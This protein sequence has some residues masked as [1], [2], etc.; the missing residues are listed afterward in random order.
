MRKFIFLISILLLPVI[1][2][3]LSYGQT[4]WYTQNSGTTSNLN[5]IF[6]IDG[7][8]GWAVGA[9]GIVVKTINRGFSWY[10]QNS[11]TII[12][13]RKIQFINSQTGWAVGGQF[14][15]QPNPFCMFSSVIIKTT[16]GGLTW[17][18]II[19]TDFGRQY[20]D[21][22]ILDSSNAYI[23][24]ES[25]DN[26]QCIMGLGNVTKTTDG[27]GW[28]SLSIPTYT[29]YINKSLSF[30]NNSTGYVTAIHS[31]DVIYNLKKIL[32]TTD[33]GINWIIKTTD[34]SSGFSAQNNFIRFFNEN[35]GYYIN[36]NF[37]KTING[38][39][40]WI[41]FDSLSVY[42]MNKF[43]FMDLSTGYLVGQNKL[44]KTSNGGTNWIT[45]SGTTFTGLNS[46]C[47]V[48]TNHVWACGTGGKIVY[49]GNAFLADTASIKY[50]PLKIGNSWTYRDETNM[51]EWGYLK[52]T[53][54]SDTL[55]NGTT[56]YKLD[57][58]FPYF[59][60]TFITS[61]SLT[62]N[63]YFFLDG[64]DCTS[65]PN[66]RLMDSLNSKP[67]DISY[68][69]SFDNV[70]S[71]CNDTNDITIFGSDQKSKFFARSPSLSG[72][73]Q[74]RYVQNFGLTYVFVSENTH[75]NT[76][77]L[78]GC[79]INN[80]IYGDTTTVSPY[81]TFLPLKVGNRWTYRNYCTFPPL[82]D[83]VTTT[84]TSETTIGGIKYFT[85]SNGFPTVSGNT[86]TLDTLTGNVFV[87]QSGSS[88]ARY[89]NR[90]LVDSLAAHQGDTVRQCPSFSTIGQCWDTT[91][92]QFGQTV[93]TKR[94]FYEGIGY[95]SRT[96]SEKFG[97]VFGSTSEVDYITHSLLSCV[98]DGVNYGGSFKTISGTI[99]FAD[100]NLSASNGYVKAIKLNTANGKIITLDSTQIG[101]NGSY[102][103]THL[104]IDSCDI[105]AYPNSENQADFVPTFYPSTIHWQ[106]ATKVYTGNN[107]SNI[108][109]SVYRKVSSLG[110]FSI[111]GW[112]RPQTA[113]VTGIKDAVVYVMQGNI[114]RDYYCTYDD[115][116]QY[117]L[118][119]LLPGSYQVIA[120]RLGYLSSQQDITITNTNLNNINFSLIPTFVGI[121][122]SSNIVPDKFNLY[123]NYPNPFNPV[124][125]IKFD[126]PKSSFVKLKIYNVLGKEV[127]VILNENKSAGSYTIDFDASTIST[128]IYFYRLETES[129]TETKRMVILK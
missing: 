49:G 14:N 18:A 35:T 13:L 38:G 124:T 33:G 75:L 73:H 45:N 7:N 79:V 83:T 69:C 122:S 46:I 101:V 44:V 117:N 12:E 55:I 5:D 3:S 111:D 43:S 54:I 90:F 100:N 95:A 96:Y 21:L 19:A 67:G 59:I 108:N 68:P 98:I 102:S 22:S 63:I 34:S 103:L 41:K 4:G 9:N 27:S 58:E 126:I 15:P 36:G 56:F 81:K 70:Y 118:N 74:R 10:N 20:N 82:D 107:P 104:P 53:I 6:F 64:A 66:L 48:D 16:N 105:V 30:I 91:I 42:G 51:G 31:S 119:Q 112:I 123:Q 77:R 29:G 23:A 89:P 47:A 114:F 80:M 65:R 8:T 25:V 128:G 84:I 94:F 88:C 106:T 61:D 39:T 1:G 32:K 28:G 24:G 50:M 99:K 110:A 97:I 52:I 62:G 11:G 71:L 125:N 2:T 26:T 87:Y 72:S 115:V 120:D 109:I 78:M 129:F 37:F 127:A 86:F 17:A 76:T 85:L 40:N 93:R 121:H 60:G 113:N 92:T 57:N 116:G